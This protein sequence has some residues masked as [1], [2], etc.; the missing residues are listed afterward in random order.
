M[1]SEGGEALRQSAAMAAAA[2][3]GARQSA[4]LDFAIDIG[5]SRF[6][7]ILDEADHFLQLVTP[8]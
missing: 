7:K 8:D 5:V 3:E 4:R 6:Y 1:G 2:T